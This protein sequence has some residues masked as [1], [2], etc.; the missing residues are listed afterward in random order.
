MCTA[1]VPS[2]GHLTQFLHNTSAHFS[3]CTC[4]RVPGAT[5]ACSLSSSYPP[6][7]GL[8]IAVDGG[9]DREFWVRSCCG[10]PPRKRVRSALKD[11]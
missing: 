9:V 3:Q 7:S 4:Q 10:A 1:H 11:E 2:S 5:A 8:L 6:L